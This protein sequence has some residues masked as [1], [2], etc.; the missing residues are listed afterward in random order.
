MSGTIRVFRS[1][2]L[3]KDLEPYLT[4]LTKVEKEKSQFWKQMCIYGMIQ[5]SKV[6]PGYNQ[7]MLISSLYF[8]DSTHN[9]FH[10][11]CRMLTPTLFDIASIIGFQPTGEIFDPSDMNGNTINFDT[12]RATFTHYI[13]DH[14]NTENDEVS[15]EE[16]IVFLA[17]W[18]SR[19]IFCSKFIQVAKRFLTMVN[20]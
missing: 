11:P 18:W 8:W 9:T 1:C 14:H 15:D 20:Q 2:P 7:N 10:F 4:W 19:C 5:L 6:G 13:S 3:S 17:L 16:H 12:N